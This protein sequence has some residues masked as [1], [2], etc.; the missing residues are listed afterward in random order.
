MLPV[1]AILLVSFLTA[2]L[3][4]TDNI[5]VTNDK[6]SGDKS[7]IDRPNI[8]LI[9]VDNLGYGDLGC[10]GSQAVITPNI[11]K[12]ASEGMRFT[13]AYA[14]SSVCAPSR[15]SLMT[16]LHAGHNSVRSNSGGVPL[17][18]E[19]VTVAEVLKTAG[20]ATG[21]FGKWG[22]GDIGTTG[23][24]EQQGFDVFYGYY[25]HLHA[26]SYYPEYLINSG[27]KV[28]MRGN[29]GQTGDKYSAYLIFD[30][31][32]RFIRS[33]HNRPFF[34]YAPW[35]PPHPSTHVYK[36]PK[37]V[38][39]IPNDDPAWKHYRDK[40]WPEEAKG[41]A[42]M[43]SMLDRHVGEILKLLIQLEIDD[44][45]I[46]FF[47]S[48][49][50]AP[51]LYNGFRQW[52]RS[53]GPLRGH[54]RQLYEGGIRVPLLVRWPGQLKPGSVSD[55][56]CYFPDFLPTLAQLAA[57][58]EHPPASHNGISF[59]PELLGRQQPKHENLYWELQRF[60]GKQGIQRPDSASLM[61]AVRSGDWKLVRHGANDP[62]ELYNLVDDQGE[63]KN[64]AA[65]QPKIVEKLAAHALDAR[66]DSRPQAEPEKPAG[67]RFR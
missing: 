64:L 11:D 18:K 47:C 14:G 45:T 12:M 9:M 58:T 10:Y 57:A 29:T 32:K 2:S 1:L 62:W 22:L 65:E 55:H 52:L 35:T 49:N 19:D 23:A 59:V 33:N 43:I 30:Q 46:V 7:I 8:I 26:H 24:P 28:P 38:Y 42:A 31:M 17:L 51:A 54:L 48:D 4:C 25:H 60:R 5:S 39:D 36:P 34:C 67:R 44:H 13:H 27:N 53:S 15:S 6:A 20:Y 63:T 50:G 21:G 3:G 56:I 16:G 66:T 41:H 37:S 61:Q 40:S